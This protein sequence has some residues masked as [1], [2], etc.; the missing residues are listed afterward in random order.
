MIYIDTSAVVKLVVEE[1]ESQ[2]LREA[3]TGRTPYAISVVGEIET[4]R[5]CRRAQI[6]ADQVDSVRRRLLVIPLAAEIADLAETIGPSEL[7]SLD[8]IHLA[9]ALSIEE[10]LEELVT[11]DVRL[12]DAA[13]EA[14]LTVLAP[15]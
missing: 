10:D 13:R 7:R 8:A 9:T 4:I 14:G 2:A 3:V 6:P 15:A 1:S 12:A 5:A 11:Y